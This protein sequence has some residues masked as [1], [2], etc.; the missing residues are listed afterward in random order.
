MKDFRKVFESELETLNPAQR[1]AVETI[2]GPVLVIAGPGTG[3]TQIIAARIGYILQNTDTRPENILCL[4]YTEAGTIAMRNRIFKFIGPE[5]YKVNIFTFHAFCNTVIQDNLDIFGLRELDPISELEEIELFR[6]LIDGF[7]NNHPLKRWRGDVYHDLRNLRSLFSLMKTENWSPELIESRANQYLED[8]R[9]SGEFLYKRANYKKGI[10][11]GDINERKF[12]LE[13]DKM[14]RLKAASREFLKYQ[15]MMRQRNRYDYNDMI[16]WVLEEFKNNQDLLLNYQERYHYFLVDEYQ[17]TNGAQNDI[18][19]QLISY[20]D[21]PNVFVVGDDDQSIFRFQGANVANILEFYE[22]YEE[23]VKVV[24]MTDNYRSS[25]NI[26]DASKS[27]IEQNDERLIKSLSMLGVS[28]NLK[29]QH[30]EFASSDVTPEIIEFHNTAHETVFIANEIEKLY[31]QGVSLNEIAIIYR[32]H[33][34][35]ESIAAYLQ[36]KKI[37]IN[38]RRKSNILESVFIGNILNLLTYLEGESRIPLSR[39]DLLFEILHYDFFNIDPLVIANLSME[40]RKTGPDKP[41]SWREVIREAGKKATNTLFSTPTERSFRNLLELSN[42]LEYWINAVHNTTV[43]VL[44]EKLITRGGILG[45]VMRSEHKVELMQELTTFFDFI[46][47]ETARNSKVRLRDILRTIRLMQEYDLGLEINKTVFAEEGVNFV[48][49][50]SAKG[51]EFEYVFLLGCNKKIWDMKGRSNTFALPPNLLRR[52]EGDEVEESRRLFYVAMTRAKHHLY[53]NYSKASSDGVQKEKSQFIAELE[54]STNIPVRSVALQDDALMEYS[55]FA[56]MEPPKPKLSLIDKQ[57]LKKLLETYS[58]SVTHLSTYLKCPVS[59][60]FNHLLRIPT[61]KNQHMAFGSAVHYALEELFRR[62]MNGDKEFPPQ[63]DFVRFFEWSMNRSRECFTDE[64]F[65]QKM[66][67]GRQILPGYYNHYVDKWNKIVSPERN[68]Q[69]IVIHGVP[70]N[71]KVDKIEFDG[72]NANVVDY[73]TGQYKN[74]KSKFMPPSLFAGEEDSFEERFGGDYWRQAVFYKILI[75]N[76]GKSWNVVSTEFDFIEPDTS[77]GE[78]YK[79]KVDIK[80]EHIDFVTAQIVETYQN[81]IDL[82]FDR[83][84]G[85]SDCKWCNFVNSSYNQI[86]EQPEEV[87]A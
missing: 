58:L 78:Y 57:H 59:F 35:C 68:M 65:A 76:S 9:S 85:K 81:I 23:K 33:K 5:A 28:K 45:Y 73:K 82:K 79:E 69:K 63:Q 1:E 56:M 19:H 20:W 74:A 21:V 53:L 6:E 86:I 36:S 18:L 43:Q 12:K 62:M 7:D 77:S 75:E 51:L 10:K 34:Q 50:H 64:E 52:N 49:A 8:C 80:P 16:L 17:D 40:F 60:Y 55:L 30:K 4:T 37:P 15:E 46:K 11:V 29:A 83:G 48:T 22:R 24:V 2:E 66:N 38:I 42:N 25:Q 44:F 71:G 54:S 13:F 31:S 27:L 84:C 3:K 72:R 47:A 70:V 26:L 41:G 14:D 32:N 67:Y 61:A 39:E 87:E